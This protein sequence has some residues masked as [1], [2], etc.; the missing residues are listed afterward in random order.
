VDPAVTEPLHAIFLSYASQDAEAAQRICEA[1]RAAGIEVWLDQSELRG[2]DAWDESIRDQIKACALFLP[3]ISANAHAR[4]EGYFRLEW[5][6]AVDRSHRMAPKQPFLLP[7]VIDD[8]PQSDDAIPDRFREL[9][10]T[11]LPGGHATPAFVERVRQ[12]LLP[13][14]GAP[15]ATPPPV[16][17]TSDGEQ[18]AKDSVRSSWWSKPASLA[19]V[20]VLALGLAYFVADRFWISK[21][22]VAPPTSPSAP[23]MAQRIGTATATFTPPAHSIAVLPFVNMSGD[24]EQEYFSDGLTEE[25]LNSLAAINELQVAARTSAFSFK[26]K[27]T[28]IGTIAR[29]LNV[30]AVLEGSVR[31]S[32]HTVRIT[33]QLID[34]VTGFHL[35]SKTYDR[36]LGDVLKLQTQ[37]ATA[38]A[39]A[40]KVTLLADTS[41]KIELGGTRNPAAFDA[42]LHATRAADAGGDK[43][44][45]SAAAAYTDAIRLD[46]NYA[47]AFAGR[48][49]VQSL[50]AS[51]NAPRSAVRLYFDKALA[52]AH[53]AIALAPDLAEGHVAL[54]FYLAN[55]ALDLKQARVEFERA[56]ALAPGRAAILRICGLFAIMTGRAE[57]G[58]ADLRRAI[59]LDPLNALTYHILGF[60]LY[61]AHRYEEARVANAEAISLD[62]D[63]LRAYEYS[64]LTDYQL[65][66]LA[67]ARATCEARPNYWGTQ[68]CLALTYEKLGRHADAQA[69]VA[70]IE[71][72]QGDTAAYQ[73]STIYAQWGDIQKALEW[74]ESAMRLRDPGLSLLKN[75]PLMDPLRKESR[76][77]AV[78]R[79]LKFPN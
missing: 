77:Q 42:Y 75:D 21:Q 22:L 30:G 68:W 16:S 4:V 46:P 6:L 36:D 34:A 24:K 70:K 61:L 5:K 62:P 1:L 7:V 58:L 57:A 76:F 31:R 27:D 64:G 33:A 41:T 17:A 38:V 59:T 44:Y 19:I 63:L 56:R 35:W 23:V 48:S 78:E 11:R 37:I 20:A 9:Q 40:L 67:G 52:D 69:A 71:A 28:D 25:L 51:Q 53:Q 60:G 73:Y 8:T 54:G 26:G 74:L 79:E 65:G 18:P 55:G 14:S 66:N 45:L 3:V 50:Y 2:G 12:L 10:W 72:L 15:I 43:N 49:F 29:K 32:S 47:L 13:E 39:D